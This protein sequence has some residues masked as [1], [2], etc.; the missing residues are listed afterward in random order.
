LDNH[1]F[2]AYLTR[3][4]KNTLVKGV[5]QLIQ[6]EESGFAKQE[7][8]IDAVRTLPE[9]GL[10]FDICITHDQLPDVITL[11]QQCPDVSFVLDHVGKPD[12][13]GGELKSWRRLIN[14]LAECNNVHCKISGMVT[15]ADLDNWTPDD[16]R[17]YVEAVVDA[18]GVSR[19]MFGGDYPVLELANTDY[20]R[21]V[22][23]ATVLLNDLSDRERQQVFYDNALKFY[24]LEGK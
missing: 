18:F 10:S 14:R 7:H 12:I 17:P 5:R 19:L 11:V 2:H 4:T 8:F 20:A 13:K 9:Y 15:E 3:V 24:R 22:Q 1:N 23:T 16:L 21:W 6:S